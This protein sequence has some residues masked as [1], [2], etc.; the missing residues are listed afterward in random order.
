MNTDK[1]K[2]RCLVLGANGF[3]GVN[4]CKELLAQGYKVRAFSTRVF[5]SDLLEKGMEI[6]SFVGNFS[7]KQD[8]TEAL[9]GV[10]VVYH[11]VSTTLPKSSNDDPVFDVTSNVGGTVAL[12]EAMRLVGVKKI[13]FLS[14]GGTVY[15]NT[16]VIPIK[17]D[18]SMRPIC[19]YG[20]GKVAIEHYLF[21][22]DQL[23]GL[24]YMVLRLSNPYGVGRKAGRPQGAIN[25]FLN[26]ALNKQTIEIWGD[27]TI[28]RDYIYID[29]VVD[30]CLKVLSCE[31][32]NEV[33]NIA[34]GKGLSLLEVIAVMEDVLGF[35][36]NYS[37]L[38]NR[39]F[40]VPTNILDISKAREF[41]GWTPKVGIHQG[42]EKTKA[43]VMD[44]LN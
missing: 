38:P 13:V 3:V 2:V 16:D 7:N 8:L 37:L 6:E 31:G 24:E 40:D 22:Y 15:G 26:A 21:M 4:L 10:D 30:A 32:W 35:K 29:D 1:S 33:L 34:S 42:I 44:Q 19:S 18:S 28:V 12:L 25:S 27:G 39:S 11:L 23:Y 17:E 36:V 43:W 9:A 41:L 20:I 14:S 5:S